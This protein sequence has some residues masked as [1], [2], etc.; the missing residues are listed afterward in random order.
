M[1]PLLD[2][3]W[4]VTTPEETRLEWLIGRHIAYGKAPDAAR[5]WALGTDERNAQV[6]HATRTR[7]DALVH[8]GP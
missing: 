2:E 3:A 8:V 4:F 6:V 7:A 5:A 1:R